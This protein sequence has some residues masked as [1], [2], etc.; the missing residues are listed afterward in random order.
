MHTRMSTNSK[1]AVYQWPLKPQAKQSAYIVNFSNDSALASSV[2]LRPKGLEKSGVKMPV[3]SNP[4]GI[5]HVY[6]Y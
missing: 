5:E 1:S 3:P 6:A 4:F 2:N